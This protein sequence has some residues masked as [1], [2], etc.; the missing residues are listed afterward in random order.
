[1][2]LG[3]AN[4]TSIEQVMSKGRINGGFVTK[5]LFR[6]ALKK[7]LIFLVFVLIYHQCNVRNETEPRLNATHLRRS[8]V[9]RTQWYEA[10]CVY[11]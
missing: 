3:F 9:R 1:M 10:R 7:G 8:S 6:A 2:Y 4:L 5:S 11:S